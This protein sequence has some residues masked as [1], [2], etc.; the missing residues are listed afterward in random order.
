MKKPILSSA[1]NVV[2]ILS[3]S[4]LQK[5]VVST[6]GNVYSYGIMLTEIFTRIK[7]KDE[8]FAGER[9]LRD[10]VGDSLHGSTVKLVT[11]IC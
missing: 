11:Q 10:W 5:G 7:P 6:R 4:L 8:H 3:Q 1:M 2:L 9:G